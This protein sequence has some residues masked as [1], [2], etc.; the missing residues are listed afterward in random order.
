MNY[1]AKAAYGIKGLIKVPELKDGDPNDFLGRLFAQVKSNIAAE[2]EALKPQ[3]EAYEAAMAAGRLA[4]D[5]IREPEDVKF[6]M[7]A[8]KSLEH[9]LTSERELRAAMSDRL[10]ELHIVYNKTKRDYERAE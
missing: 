9:A 8:I 2:K 1:N 4:I 7:D 3:Q 5:T 10:K 6:A